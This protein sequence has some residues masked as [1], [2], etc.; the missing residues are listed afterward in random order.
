MKKFMMFCFALFAC[1]A[2]QAQELP[3]SKYLN[4]NNEQFKEY[5]FKY[6][7]YTN[8]WSLN[9]VNGLNT[10]LNILAIIAD[11]SE[12]VRPAKND[13][14]IIVQ[15][16]EDKQASYVKV[17][18]YN[19][20][21][22][23]KL[24][25]FMKENGKDMVETT[26]GKIVKHQAFYNDYSLELNMDQHFISRTSSRT[27]DRKTVKNVDESYNEYDFTIRTG[28]EPWSEEIEKQAAKQAKRD[29]KGK[30]KQSVEDLM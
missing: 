2:L 8:I 23:H 6:D 17:R 13:Y 11:A 20:E 10:T 7:D 18:F 27:A 14:S 15:M 28:V 4:F 22:Y 25:T 19:D 5:N 9:K 3:Y 24:L 12:E 29:A 26:S 30:K 16:G 1:I 21:T